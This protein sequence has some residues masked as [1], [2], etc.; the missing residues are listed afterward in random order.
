MLDT[1]RGWHDSNLF[2]LDHL[3]FVKKISTQIELLRLFGLEN[4]FMF[5]NFYSLICFLTFSILGFLESK[6]Y[7]NIGKFVYLKF[8]YLI[9][10]I[11]VV[12]FLGIFTDESGF[13]NF[14]AI[15]IFKI[16]ISLIGDNF[17][18]QVCYCCPKCPLYILKIFFYLIR[19]IF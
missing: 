14:L 8:H 13:I 10:S 7:R 6:N 12:N 18:S 5:L 1:F 15:E 11:Y 9:L 16:A 17:I 4:F 3:F 19:V 2:L